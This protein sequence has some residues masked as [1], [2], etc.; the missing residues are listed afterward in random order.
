MRLTQLAHVVPTTGSVSSAGSR[1]MTRQGYYRGVSGHRLPVIRACARSVIHRL[2]WRRY[3]RR[4]GVEPTDSASARDV[5]RRGHRVVSNDVTIADQDQPTSGRIRDRAEAPVLFVVDDDLPTLE[6]LRDVARASG[7]NSVRLHA[8]G[9]AAGGPWTGGCRPCSSSTTTCRTVAAGTWPATCA[10]T[11]AGGRPTPGVHG[12]TGDAP[13]RDRLLG[14]GGGEAVRARRDRGVPRGRS[15]SQRP[16]P[17]VQGTA[18]RLRVCER[19]SSATSFR[20]RSTAAPGSTST[21]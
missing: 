19:S 18:A 2:F 20:R 16:R 12:G 3:R 1:F 7:W 5:Q 15:A 10:A 6:L 11:P 14:T 8:P 9:I 17:R 4:E 13:C 21:S